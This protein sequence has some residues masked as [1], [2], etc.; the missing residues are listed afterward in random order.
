MNRKAMKM[1]SGMYRNDDKGSLRG[2]RGEGVLHRLFAVAACGVVLV[3]ALWSGGVQAQASGSLTVTDDPTAAN[4]NTV[5]PALPGG[6]GTLWTGGSRTFPADPDASAGDGNQVYRGIVAGLQAPAPACGIA[7]AEVTISVRVTN[8]GPAAGALYSGELSLFSGAPSG[9]P[10]S[11]NNAIEQVVVTPS[12]PVNSPVVLTITQSVPVADL[13]AGNIFIGLWLETFHNGGKSWTASQFQGTYTYDTTGCETDLSITKDD[14]VTTYVPG[15]DATYTIVVTNDGPD[16]AMGARITDPLPAG[17]TTAS[18]T[19]GNAAGGAVCGAA[20]G[21]GGIDTTADLPAGSSATYRL[22]VGIPGSFS[23]SLTNTATVTAPVG[24]TD[25]DPDN[26][27]ASDTNTMEPPPT[28]G[29]CS[30]RNVTPALSFTLAP[31]PMTGT[32]NRTGAP[33]GWLAENPWSTLG[34]NYTIQWN[35]SQPIP[36]EWL[37]FVLID[38]DT[39]SPNGTLTISLGGGVPTSQIVKIGGDLLLN[40]SGVVRRNNASTNDPGQSAT[41]G[42]APGG[43]ITWLR[44]TSANIANS[45][46]IGHRILVRPACMT[47][48]KVS[49]DDTGSFTIEM[50]NV[51]EGDGTAIPS[52]TLTTSTPG[53]PVSTPEIYSIRPGF[54]MTL[55]EVVP[56]GWN[57]ESAV[58]TD[59]NAGNTGNPTVIGT[60]VSPAI[61]IPDANVRPESDIRCLFTNSEGDVAD[62][63]IVKTVSPEAV[64]SGDEVVYT[65]QVTNNGPDAA[66]GAVV[67]DPQPVGLD[68]STGTLTCGS[69]TGGTV[70]PASPTVADLQGAGITIPT[71]PVGGSLQFTLTCTV[72]ASG[73]P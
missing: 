38:I 14:G 67:T 54:A 55:S 36:V 26:N 45:D 60:F 73:E 69:E 15:F 5:H 40:S 31:F 11:S 4:W 47:V 34:G 71:F 7:T 62:L 56:A 53:T 2:D 72:T 66:D 61:T 43:S 20:S 33:N 68:C 50:T 30:P 57:L 16:D 29:V 48:S 25:T 23:G 41:F 21:T 32:V 46:H 6:G 22:T 10:F 9:S 28:S 13:V 63:A 58:C 64:V 18:W 70:C 12:T 65:L 3:S 24:V 35:F 1:H 27:T 37:R 44:V 59:Q 51:A 8:N 42:F 39:V 17:I 19:C 49:E 52:T